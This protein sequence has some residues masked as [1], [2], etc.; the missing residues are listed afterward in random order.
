MNWDFVAI[1]KFSK[2]GTNRRLWDRSV[3]YFILAIRYRNWSGC[4]LF[5]S[6]ITS[7]NISLLITAQ[8]KY[9]TLLRA[10]TYDDVIT[11]C[12]ATRARDQ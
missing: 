5:V 2:S 9:L 8:V 4:C 12:S 6:H 11:A 10:S 7:D 3:T 1:L